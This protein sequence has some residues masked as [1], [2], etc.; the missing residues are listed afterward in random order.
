VTA[1]PADAVSAYHDLL[2][3]EVAAETQAQLESQLRGRGLY[4]GDRPLCT[5]VRPRLM[6]P[7][8]HRAL[9]SGVARIGRAV[10]RG[11]QAAM[12]ATA[13]GLRRPPHCSYASSSTRSTPCL[14]G[15]GRTS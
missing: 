13:G 15:R 9:Q 10:G 4:F 14:A 5:V 3:D 1:T 11:P 12:G 8:Q 2:T 6:S 7:A